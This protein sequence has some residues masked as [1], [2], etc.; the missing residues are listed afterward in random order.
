MCNFRGILALTHE[1]KFSKL[2]SIRFNV[3][4]CIVCG[5]DAAL[6]LA[7]ILKMLVALDL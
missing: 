1:S 3:I 7:V 6:Q 4:S 5:S 2:H